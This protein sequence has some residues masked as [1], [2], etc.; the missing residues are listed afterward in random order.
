MDGNALCRLLQGSLAVWRL[1]GVVTPEGDALAVRLE[2][3]RSARVTHVAEPFPCWQVT[4]SYGRTR[5]HAS[6]AAMLRALRRAL[7][8]EHAAARL[9]MA[10]PA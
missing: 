1:T 6:V 8:P 2:G 4:D 10:R 9:V 5:P 3:G 7:D